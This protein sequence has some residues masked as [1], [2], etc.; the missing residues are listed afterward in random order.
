MSQ[1]LVFT[2]NSGYICSKFRYNI[3][4]YLKTAS[5][6]TLNYI[7]LSKQIIRDSDVKNIRKCTRLTC[8]WIIIC[9][10]QCWNTIRDTHL[11]WPTWP[12]WEFCRRYRMIYHKSW[13]ILKQIISFTFYTRLQLCVAA[14]GG[15][16]QHCLNPERAIRQLTIITETFEPLVKSCAKFDVC[17]SWTIKCLSLIHIWRCRRSYACRS[18]WSPYH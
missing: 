17:Y 11:N 9:G 3:L 18:R 14:A 2:Q 4:F 16:Y 10:V 15:H 7:F 8:K 5:I 6:W 1:N 12:S 13:F